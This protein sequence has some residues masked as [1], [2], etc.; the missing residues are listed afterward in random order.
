MIDNETAEII[1]EELRFA[2]VR[3]AARVLPPD[4]KDDIRAIVAFVSMWTAT[5]QVAAMKYHAAH[6]MVVR[7]PEKFNEILAEYAA[8]EQESIDRTQQEIAELQGFHRMENLPPRE[9]PSG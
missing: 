4:F 2:Y 8:T 3:A 1:T 7:E 6:E 9:P 5:I